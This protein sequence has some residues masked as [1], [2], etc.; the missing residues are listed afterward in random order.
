MSEERSD[1]DDDPAA[2]Q[3]NVRH[4]YVISA[5]AYFNRS[6][7]MLPR[8]AADKTVLFYCAFELRCAIE[9][10]FYEYLA[11]L[12]SD[13]LTAKE[14]KLWSAKDLKAA[15]LTIDPEFIAKVDFLNVLLEARGLAHRFT[16][17][18]LDRLSRDY[19][20]LHT[21][22]HA[23]R[24]SPSEL[25]A[26]RWWVKLRKLIEDLH[27]YA[28]PLC[29]ETRVSIQL[30]VVAEDYFEDFQAKRKSREETVEA[31]RIIPEGFEAAAQHRNYFD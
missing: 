13:K 27:D 31:L 5:W 1:P 14:V 8:A 23:Q 18:D 25:Y 7:D 21:Y 10:V 28:W 4:P 9:R 16:I 15:V 22:L 6:F 12:R 24:C 3:E 19:G 30:N 2:W 29:S 20:R 11:H 26:P 17:P